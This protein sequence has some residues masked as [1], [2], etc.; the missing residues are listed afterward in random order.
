MVDRS[1]GPGRPSAAASFRRVRPG[2][3]RS[4]I[5]LRGDRASR[6]TVEH[7][8]HSCELGGGQ[9]GV[10]P[11]TAHAGP[12]HQER[13]LLVARY[14]LKGLQLLNVGADASKARS[15]SLRFYYVPILCCAGYVPDEVGNRTSRDV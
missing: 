7:H 9:Q 1:A 11:A 6:L 13:R 3:S 12:D 2:W 14:L 4:V 15:C 5:V 8:I 10:K